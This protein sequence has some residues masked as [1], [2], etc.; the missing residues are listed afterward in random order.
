MGFFLLPMPQQ[1]G[2][3]QSRLKAF[4][5]MI[6]ALYRVGAC[7]SARIPLV[8]THWNAALSRRFSYCPNIGDLW[9][10]GT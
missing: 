5:G 8:A 10:T 2:A 7:I 9:R 6:V 4:R 1:K 3:A